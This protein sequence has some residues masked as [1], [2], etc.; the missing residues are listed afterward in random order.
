[1]LPK[2]LDGSFKAEDDMLKH[3][4]HYSDMCCFHGTLV[5]ASEAK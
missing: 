5:Q 2:D 1:M 4:D 3:H